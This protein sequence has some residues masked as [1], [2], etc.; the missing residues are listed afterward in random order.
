MAPE[1][2]GDLFDDQITVEE[3]YS[4]AFE[5]WERAPSEHIVDKTLEFLTK[6][7]LVDAGLVRV[8]LASMQNSLEVRVPFLDDELVEFVR[9]L[10]HTMKYRNGQR[11]Y[12]LKKALAGVVPDQVLERRKKG[13]GIPVTK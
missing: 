6:L 8:D 11:K 12:L 7:S 10:P 4:T 3:L 1:E 2:I 5:V 9:R 13:F